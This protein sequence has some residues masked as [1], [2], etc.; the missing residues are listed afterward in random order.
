MKS[1]QR[2]M[3]V[4]AVCAIALAAGHFAQS[5]Q[6]STVHAASIGPVALPLAEKDP[7][8]SPSPD[9]LLT[10]P[11]LIE[12]S[13]PSL[14]VPALRPSTSAATLLAPPD[15]AA[16]VVT[17]SMPDCVPMLALAARPGATIDML[18]AGTCRPN[19]RVVLRH[20]GLAVTYRTNEAGALFASIPAFQPDAAVSI[21]FAGGVRVDGTISVPDAQMFRRFGVQ[22]LGPQAFQVNA[23]ENGADYGQVGHVSVASPRSPH[24]DGGFLTELGDASVEL[25]M[26]AEIYTFPKSG[27]PVS[28]LVEAAVTEAT[29]GQDMLGDLMMAD[30]GALTLSDLSV[31]M[32]GCDATGDYLVLKNLVPDLKLASAN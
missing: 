20:A 26:L 22:W 8:N 17:T 13:L 16:A 25:P 28:V 15:G 32:P 27:V 6:R 2:V 7:Q 5:G 4:L 24:P 10:S 9:P 31:T 19:E 29:C 12:A 11:A 30:R 18:L 21:R 3:R 1:G 23:F 14:P